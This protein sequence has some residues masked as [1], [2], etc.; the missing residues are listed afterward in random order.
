MTVGE[1]L[2]ERDSV[3][4]RQ[5]LE[6]LYLYNPPLSQKEFTVVQ[7]WN[8]RGLLTDVQTSIWLHLDPHESHHD[9]HRIRA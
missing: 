5:K 3:A 1:M 2:V 9:V 8:R 6:S 4:T 7:T